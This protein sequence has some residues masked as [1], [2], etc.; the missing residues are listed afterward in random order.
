MASGHEADFEVVLQDAAQEVPQANTWPTPGE[1]MWRRRAEMGRGK[2]PA[3]MWSGAQRAARSVL[4]LAF[5]PLQLVSLAVGC[6]LRMHS[7]SG[8]TSLEATLL[9]PP[10]PV[11]PIQSSIGGVIDRSL[12]Y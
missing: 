7:L 1:E 6:P 2:G 10:P 8:R 12:L 3:E 4:S 5:K 9:S 11:P